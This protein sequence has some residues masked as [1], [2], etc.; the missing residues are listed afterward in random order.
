MSNIEYEAKI[1]DVDPADIA[2]KLA[3]LD[4]KEVGSYIFAVTCLI[5]FQLSQIAGCGCALMGNRR[6]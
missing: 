2:G 1:Y 6:L 4:A 5:R 3:K